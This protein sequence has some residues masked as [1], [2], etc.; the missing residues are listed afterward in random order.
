M[1]ENGENPGNG[2]PEGPDEAKQRRAEEALRDDPL[3][4][5]A[6]M[7]ASGITKRFGGL[8]AVNAVDFTIPERAIVSLIGPNGAGKTTFFNMVSGLLGPTEGS[9][10]FRGED[11]TKKKAHERARMGIGRTFQNIRLFGTMSVV[12]NV[13]TGMHTRLRGRILGAIL[14]LPGTRREEREAL[15]RAEELLAFVGIRARQ[16]FAKNLSYGDQRRLEIARALAGEPKLL[17]LDEPT[18]GMNPQETARLTQLI[19]RLRDE[20]NISILLIEHEMKVVM[21][22]S[23]RVTV[24]DHGEKISEGLPAEVREDPKVIEA[25]LGTAKTG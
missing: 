19:G 3:I 18:A 8:V 23:D 24:L 2:T 20:M 15:D 12:D 17:L 5:E 9:F 1:S 14:G 16:T 13:L 25:Y 21:S 6:I 11:V 7:T 22:I 4:G 10:V